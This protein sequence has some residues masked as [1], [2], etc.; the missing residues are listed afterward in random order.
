MVKNPLNKNGRTEEFD[1]EGLRDL[2]DMAVRD[3]LK[4]EFGTIV[5]VHGK[6]CPDGTYSDLDCRIWEM[7][8]RAIEYG[9]FL[10]ESKTTLMEEWLT[11]LQ[12]GWGCEMADQIK[13]MGMEE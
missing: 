6:S 4:N 2:M 13:L 12:Y 11:E 5:M 9:I 7:F 1:Y 10:K 8:K 3:V